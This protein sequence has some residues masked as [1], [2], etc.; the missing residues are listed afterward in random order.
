MLITATIIFT[1]FCIPIQFIE[2][3]FLKLF[4]DKVVCNLA[5]IYVRCMCFGIIPYLWGFSYAMFASL[6]GKPK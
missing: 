1:P 4:E 3:L 6:Q 5:A 2:T